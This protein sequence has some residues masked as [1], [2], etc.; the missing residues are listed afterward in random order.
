MCVKAKMGLGEKSHAW[1]RQIYHMQNL[2]GTVDSKTSSR[3]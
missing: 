1:V 2:R 3:G